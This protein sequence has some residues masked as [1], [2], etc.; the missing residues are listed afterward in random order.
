MFLFLLNQ[1]DA[2]V[3]THS[4]NLTSA[5]NTSNIHLSM[6]KVQGKGKNIIRNDSMKP[7][8]SLVKPAWVQSNYSMRLFILTHSHVLVSVCLC[9][10]KDHQTGCK[11]SH[12]CLCKQ[13]CGKGLH[14]HAKTS[15]YGLHKSCMH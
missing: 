11:T 14:S 1:K 4:H 2:K 10:H 5:H 6:Q 15:A 9:S 13:S 8:S 3:L 7:S 12:T